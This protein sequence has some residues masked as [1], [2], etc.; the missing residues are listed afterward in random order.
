MKAGIVTAN[1]T[2]R[3]AKIWPFENPNES[4]TAISFCEALIHKNSSSETIIPANNNDPIN[5]SWPRNKKLLKS[6][7]EAQDSLKSF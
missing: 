4:N 1:S 7:A 3:Q 2:A 5:S 6:I